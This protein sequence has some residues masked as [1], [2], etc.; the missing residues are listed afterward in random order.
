M[1]AMTMSYGVGQRED[2]K[3]IRAGDQIRSDVVSGDT[4]AYLENIAV[5]RQAP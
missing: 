4:E 5:T 1:G 2:L 3:K